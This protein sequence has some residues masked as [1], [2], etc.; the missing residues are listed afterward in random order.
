MSGSVEGDVL[1]PL[2]MLYADAMQRDANSL[3]TS[4][5]SAGDTVAVRMANTV[6]LSGLGRL[7]PILQSTNYHAL[8]FIDAGAIAAA[9]A[10]AM[11]AATSQQVAASLL[12]V[13]DLEAARTM[14]S[15][16]GGALSGFLSRNRRP[17]PVRGRARRNAMSVPAARLGHSGGE[18]AGPG[19]TLI[20]NHVASLAEQTQGL[21]GSDEM[22]DHFAEIIDAVG[23]LTG[24][25]DTS[26][27]RG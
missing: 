8:N 26:L 11:S 23:R 1:S 4:S 7:G 10:Q 14:V 12:A 15:A 24:G 16:F 9:N 18:A 5:L 13:G 27:L 3:D 22:L 25:I 6:I 2:L 17:E 20:R 19:A 21:D